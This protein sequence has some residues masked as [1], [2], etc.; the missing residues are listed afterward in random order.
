M[1]KL[2][3]AFCV[4]ALPVLVVGL[5]LNATVAEAG[6]YG[7]GRVATQEEVAAWNIDVRPDGQGLPEGSG[8]V[9]AGEEIFMEKCASCHG[10][11]GEGAGAWP[12]LAGGQDTI[13]S[14]DPV[15][16]IG[17]YWPYLSTVFDYVNRAMPFGNAQSLTA[18]ETY[19]IIAYLLYLNDMMDEDGSLSKA[20]FTDVVMPN[21][22]GFIADDRLESPIAKASSTPCM[23]DCKASVE[24]TKR[25]RFVDVTPDEEKPAAEEEAAAAPIAEPAKVVLVGDPKKGEK[26]FKK[27]KAC[28]TTE[29]GKHRSGPSLAT[30]FG[31]TAANVDGFKKYSKAMKNAGLTWDVE[32]LDAFLTKPRKFLKG[33][34]MSFS[35]IK[36]EADRM[37]MIAYLQQ[38]QI[39]NK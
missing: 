6:K 24:I 10:E 17:S 13:D 21:E 11:F 22:G 39:D 28:H 2:A 5:A 8:T 38:L 19:S 16:T 26:V 36:K 27:C 14:E 31:A 30:I 15:K 29:V 35:G 4:K 34:K 12:V 9:L 20:T 1:L 23:K 3:K 37:N 7:L 18:D 32:T 33:T 25:A